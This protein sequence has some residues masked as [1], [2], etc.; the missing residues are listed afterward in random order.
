M[1][2]FDY[3]CVDVLVDVYVWLCSQYE[4]DMFTKGEYKYIPLYISE[5]VCK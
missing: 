2:T 4:Q 5:L 1:Y 3:E